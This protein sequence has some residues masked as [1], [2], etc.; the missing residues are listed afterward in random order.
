MYEPLGAHHCHGSEDE[1]EDDGDVEWRRRSVVVGAVG[2]LEG[3]AHLA[4][5]QGEEAASRVQGTLED[6]WRETR[7]FQVHGEARLRWL[8][9]VERMTV[10]M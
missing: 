5:V 8:G 6:S 9:H 4:D 1:T 10:K 7:T 3:A 2:T